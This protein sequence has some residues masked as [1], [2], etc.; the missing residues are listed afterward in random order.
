MKDAMMSAAKAVLRQ[1]GVGIAGELAV[2]EIEK[3]D[4]RD[5]IGGF[6]RVTRRFRNGRSDQT[7]N[8]DPPAR[9]GVRIYVSHVDLLA[10]IVFSFKPKLFFFEPGS[11]P[12]RRHVLTICVGG[13]LGSAVVRKAVVWRGRL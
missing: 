2:S 12:C 11:A 7:G 8:C 3:L 1:N 13:A 6:D 9:R 5:E 4:A 10:L